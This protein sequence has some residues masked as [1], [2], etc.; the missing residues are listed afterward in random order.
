MSSAGSGLSCSKHPANGIATH[1]PMLAVAK[2]RRNDR[3]PLSALPPPI[4]TDF[5]NTPRTAG[6][7]A[8]CPAGGGIIGRLS[9]TQ[10]GGTLNFCHLARI[11]GRLTLWHSVPVT[12]DSGGGARLSPGRRADPE[13][14]RDIITLVLSP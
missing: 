8:D 6:L 2:V 7:Y 13:N 10:A 5:R 4:K 1:I 3:T 12:V 11:S 14:C 9:R